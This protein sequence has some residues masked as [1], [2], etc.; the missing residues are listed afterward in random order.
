MIKWI[1]LDI[2]STIV[3]E[4]ICENIRVDETLTQINSPPKE[5]FIEKMKYYAKLN[6]DAYK[7]A[8][9]DYS[10]QKCKWRPEYEKLYP[11]VNDVLENLHG[12]YKLGII[13]NQSSGL[14]E[15]LVK[16]GIYNYFDLI[17]SSAE[18]GLSKPSVE[19]FKLALK[20]AQC[21]PN[22]SVMVGDRL[23]NDIIPA[24][25]IGMKT[26]WIRQGYGGLGNLE[27]LVIKPNFVI[28]KI[29]ELLELNYS[30]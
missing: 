17:I 30:N 3:D 23:D 5:A 9:A 13:A 16:F 4:E 19:I 22:E 6:K 10:L 15:R 7:N 27:E 28:D 20:K 25:L 14:K 24:Q 8:L 11:N 2:G 21:A 18:V 12:K 1:F 26:V 29:E